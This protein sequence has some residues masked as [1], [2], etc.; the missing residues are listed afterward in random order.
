MYVYE[1]GGQDMPSRIDNLFRLRL[2]LSDIVYLTLSYTYVSAAKLAFVKI[3]VFPSCLNKNNF[4]S[5]PAA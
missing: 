2:S 5:T 1:F 3:R 4:F